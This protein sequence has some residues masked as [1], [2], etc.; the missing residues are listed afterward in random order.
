[1]L[2]NWGY[3]AYLTY[4]DM[5]DMGIWGY[6]GLI[7]MFGYGGLGLDKTLRV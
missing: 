7:T 6:K 1:M 3:Y 5:C 2:T 4:E